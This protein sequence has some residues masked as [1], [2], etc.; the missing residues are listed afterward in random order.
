MAVITE[1]TEPDVNEPSTFWAAVFGFF[2]AAGRRLMPEIVVQIQEHMERR[3]LD[4]SVPALGGV[5]PRQAADDP[6]RRDDL[7]RLIDGFPEPRTR[8]GVL[9]LP[10]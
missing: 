1:L 7:V 8:L 6:T 10:T 2:S 5:T 9:Q 3:W 4:E